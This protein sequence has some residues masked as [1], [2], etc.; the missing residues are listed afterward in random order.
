M[1]DMAQ[2]VGYNEHVDHSGSAVCMLLVTKVAGFL[3]LFVGFFSVYLTWPAVRSTGKVEVAV[4][5]R[6]ALLILGSY[7]SGQMGLTVNQLSVDFG[8]SNPS[9]PTQRKPARVAQR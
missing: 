6:R 8:G 4:Y 1:L 3:R 2:S 5:I 9:L 7:Q